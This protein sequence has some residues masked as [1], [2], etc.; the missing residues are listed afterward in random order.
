[1]SIDRKLGLV[2]IE[3]VIEKIQEKKKNDDVDNDFT[4]IILMMKTTR[5]KKIKTT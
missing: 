4:K 3:Y 2:N 5:E 1:M